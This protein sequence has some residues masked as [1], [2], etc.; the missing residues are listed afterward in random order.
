MFHSFLK[1]LVY[2]KSL[3]LLLVRTDYER[4]LLRHV[5]FLEWSLFFLYQ[6]ML[7]PKSYPDFCELSM[8]RQALKVIA[9]FQVRLFSIFTVAVTGG[10]G[11]Q[12]GIFANEGPE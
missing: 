10:T 8:P 5:S 3:V 9:V 6:S 2:Q 4:D 12:E 1:M 7:S 11:T